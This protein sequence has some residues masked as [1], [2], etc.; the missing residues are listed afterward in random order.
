MYSS[1]KTD[2]SVIVIISDSTLL[3]SLRFQYVCKQSL[4]L[5]NVFT[6]AIDTDDGGSCS[7]SSTLQHPGHDIPSISISTVLPTD[8]DKSSVVYFILPVSQF[9]SL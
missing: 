6:I 2:K 9:V 7:N 1:S 5:S 4:Q 8:A 3:Q